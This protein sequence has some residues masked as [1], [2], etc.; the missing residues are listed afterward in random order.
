MR[1]LTAALLTPRA[2]AAAVKLANSAAWANVSKCGSGSR[3]MEGRVEEEGEGI[4]VRSHWVSNAMGAAAIPACHRA[5]CRRGRWLER[6]EAA[7][8]VDHCWLAAAHPAV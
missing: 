8:L 5:A 2:L 7:L 4:L 1:W 3:L 6:Q